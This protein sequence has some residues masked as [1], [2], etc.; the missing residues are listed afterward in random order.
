MSDTW[1]YTH[2]GTVYGPISTDQ[3]LRLA[4]TGGL[5]PD[6]RIW[7]ESVDPSAAVLAEAALVFPSPVPAGT[8]RLPPT[9]SLP[10][11]VRALTDAVLEEWLVELRRQLRQTSDLGEYGAAALRREWLDRGFPDPPVTRTIH[12]I[13]RRRG[14]LDGPRRQRRPAPPPGWYLTEVAARR[15][16]RDRFDRIEGLALEGG[17]EVQTLTAVSLHG[18][19]AATRSGAPEERSAAR[20]G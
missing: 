9:A 8:P 7:P 18:G 11:W 10:E 6:D 1:F 20:R 15:V 19:L 13:L 14:R 3:L 17:A 12:R 16:E 2:A 5:R 4:A